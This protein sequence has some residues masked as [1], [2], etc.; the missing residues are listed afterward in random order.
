MT[1]QPE[2]PA[3]DEP[4]SNTPDAAGIDRSGDARGDPLH[5]VDAA[6]MSQ[7]SAAAPVVLGILSIILSPILLGLFF[8]PLGL[9][10]GI[11]L[12]RRGTRTA[13][14]VLAIATGFL[15]VVL[16]ITMALVWGS[17]LAS[18]LLGRDAMRAA[19]GWRGSE[20][21]V[22]MMQSLAA[23]GSREIDLSQP[24]EGAPRHAILVIGVGWEPC[25]AA[26]R[27]LSEAADNHPDVP[28]VVLDRGASAEEMRAF[29]RTHGTGSVERFLFVGMAASL[30]TPIDQAAAL[31][32]LILVGPDRK[33]E[34]AVVGAHPSDDIEKLLRGDA[35]RAGVGSSSG[36]R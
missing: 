17:V 26:L 13:G 6:W 34:H 16:S 20:V 1:A 28:I 23:G 2:P 12:Y 18:V 19:E 22:A 25:A 4:S 32:T 10:S 14:T 3:H 27:S 33:V 29:A 11:D 9:R 35:A 31:P 30:P 21:R 24:V 7:R 36:A 15:G 8:G 5:P